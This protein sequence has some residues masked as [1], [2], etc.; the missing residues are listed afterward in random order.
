MRQS[1]VYAKRTA[2]GHYVVVEAVGGRRNPNIT[3]IMVL[4]FSKAK[5]RSMIEQG[6]T[7][8]EMLYSHD[9]KTLAA[10]DIEFNK[11]NRVTATQFASDEAIAYTSRSPLFDTTVTQ[12][13]DGVK[14]KTPIEIL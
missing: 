8:G 13:E 10:L 11:K 2:R 14:E 5:W 7:L 4:Q 9:P 3:P 1:F 12:P 6:K